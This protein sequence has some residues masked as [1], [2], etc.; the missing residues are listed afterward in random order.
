MSLEGRAL[1]KKPKKKK[2][3]ILTRQ[4]RRVS[5]SPCLQKVR[6]GLP[7]CSRG[8]ESTQQ[9]KGQSLIQEDPTC[10]EA[11]KPVC[12][13]YWA[14]TPQLPKPACLACV[15]HKRS[16]SA[17][18]KSSPH[19]LQLEKA[20]VQQRRPTMAKKHINLFL[21]IPRGRLPLAARIWIQS[22]P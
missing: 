14:N 16:L 9:C 10:C 20:C 3:G 12:H 4:E 17:A 8:W 21:K 11:T 6:E 18:K 22:H 2:N 1:N 15:L 5:C 13:K 19:S 7:W